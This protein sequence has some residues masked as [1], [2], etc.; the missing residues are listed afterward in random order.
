M[1]ITRDRGTQREVGPEIEMS[2]ILLFL[3]QNK[4]G[5]NSLKRMHP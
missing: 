4:N 5:Q 2:S 3:N 1:S